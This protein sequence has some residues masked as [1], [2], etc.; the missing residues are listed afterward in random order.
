MDAVNDSYLL[1][2]FLY[3]LIRKHFAE[4]ER[5]RLDI[6]ELFH[7][8]SL[9]TEVGQML[10]LLSQPQGRKDPELL[11]NFTMDKYALTRC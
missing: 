9:Q 2:S 11:K 5:M 4:D 3:F 6:T 1:S 7:K 8:V 10:D